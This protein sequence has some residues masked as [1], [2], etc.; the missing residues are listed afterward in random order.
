[1][2]TSTNPI[3][4]R[5]RHPVF[6]AKTVVILVCTTLLLCFALTLMPLY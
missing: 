5:S 1:M 6:Y 3:H 4:V 2:T